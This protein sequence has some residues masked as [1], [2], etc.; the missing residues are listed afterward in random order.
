MQNSPNNG[1]IDY[2]ANFYG[3]LGGGEGF[4]GLLR[5]TGAPG[6]TAGWG[7]IVKV[8]KNAKIYAYNGNSCT[9]AKTDS[10]YFY[11][12][13]NIYAQNGTLLKITASLCHW[14]DELNTKYTKSLGFKVNLS[15]IPNTK[16]SGGEY[17]NYY[18]EE[19]EDFR[20]TI[21]NAT[22]CATTKYGQGIGSGAGYIER[23][24]GEYHVYNEDGNS[25][26]TTEIN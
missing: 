6:G 5:W 22:T 20:V 14:S 9:L 26:F 23:Y 7:G 12:P 11:T 25:N 8:S 15:Q 2:G 4:G 19:G 18:F 24:N 10:N 3:T 13:V 1:H 21:R 17:A 16:D